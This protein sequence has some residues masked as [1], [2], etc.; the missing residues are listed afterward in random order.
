MVPHHT[1]P[2]MIVKRYCG[3]NTWRVASWENITMPKFIKKISCINIYTRDLFYK[4]RHRDIFPGSDPPSIFSA[5]TFHNH[6]RDGMMWDHY[7]INTEI[8]K[9]D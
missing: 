1:I 5:I 9:F 2:N 3:E 4:F 7:A 8:E 6:V